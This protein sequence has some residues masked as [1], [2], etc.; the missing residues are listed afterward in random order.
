MTDNSHVQDLRCG[1]FNLNPAGSQFI[2]IIGCSGS[3]YLS[4]KQSL[5]VK[6]LCNKPQDLAELY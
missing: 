6:T 2:H 4:G 5:R 3:N 1:K